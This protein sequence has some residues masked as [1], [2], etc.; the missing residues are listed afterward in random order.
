MHHNQH[1]ILLHNNKINHHQL[2]VHQRT[3]FEDKIEGNFNNIRE[4]VDQVLII[5]T[6][7]YDSYYLIPT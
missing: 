3:N 1:T 2:Q 7:R 4:I 5:I 6:L